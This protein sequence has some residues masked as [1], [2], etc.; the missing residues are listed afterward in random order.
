M[1]D[2]LLAISVALVVALWSQA[3]NWG[4]R[5]WSDQYQPSISQR[6][7]LPATYFLLDKPIAYVAPLLAHSSRFYQIADIALPVVPN[8]KFDRRIRT[9]LK[10]PLP[11]GIWEM[12]IRGKPVRESL[13]ARYSLAIDT[14]KT[15]VEIEGAHP[16]STIEACPLIKK[17]S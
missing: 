8:G 9:G 2:N 11:G 3:G 16:G 12:H 15:C 13:L 7:N 10:T 6:L 17:G 1:H 5:P 4:R 14:S